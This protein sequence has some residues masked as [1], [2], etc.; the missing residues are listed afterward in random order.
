MRLY[1]KGRGRLSVWHD[2]GTF[3][4]WLCFDEPCFAQAAG[5]PH[6]LQQVLPEPDADEDV[7]ERVQAGV[8][9]RQALGN[10]SSYVKT[11]HRVT[12]G[13]GG[14]GRLCGLHYEQTIER[15]L[16][17]NKHKYHSEDDT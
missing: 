16:R 13:D 10:L 14:V 1:G 7:Q 2:R 5:T 8:S 15:Q 4:N 3:G 6:D 11:D 12:I 9:V 17:E